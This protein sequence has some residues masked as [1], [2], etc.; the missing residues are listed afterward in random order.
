MVKKQLF[1]VI[2][3]FLFLLFLLCSVIPVCPEPAEIKTAVLVSRD[4]R[5]YY[6]TVESL[7]NELVS[8]GN[9]RIEEFNIG[10]YKRK[11]LNKIA[12]HIKKKKF[13][14]CI[15]IGPEAAFFIWK[16]IPG[17]NALKC[18]TM[19]LAPEKIIGESAENCGT[20]LNIPPEIQVELISGCFPDINRIGILYDPAHNTDFLNKTLRYALKTDLR[21]VP[22]SISSKKNIPSVLKKNWPAIDA[23]LFIP[24]ET[25]I[26][27]SIIQ[28]IITESI[29]KNIPV[30][31]Y[32][33]FFYDRGAALAFVID[34]RETGIQTARQAAALINSR[35]CGKQ[36]PPFNALLNTRIAGLLNLKTDLTGFPQIKA[37]P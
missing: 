11:Q 30:I 25:V 13:D 19:V 1:S 2:I 27:E 32:N 10:R 26:S 34:Y 8:I 24:D 17:L 28:Y 12:D 31:G 5:P 9:F 22:L 6:E 36:A 16:D 14:I 7:N 15:A 21:I 23:L 35:E 20:S 29:R 18:Y 4:I 3:F 33:R 37:G